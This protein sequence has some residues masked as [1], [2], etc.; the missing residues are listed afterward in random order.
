[1]TANSAP[2]PYV[3]KADSE[4]ISNSNGEIYYAYKAF[5]GNSGK[6]WYSAASS[7]RWVMFD[8][9]API[10][11]K[12]VRI[13]PPG[14]YFDVGFFPQEVTIMGSDDGENWIAIATDGGAEYVPAVNSPRI[15]MF[16]GAVTYR[17]FKFSFGLA[18]NGYAQSVVG[19][20]QFAV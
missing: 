2:A 8:A 9:G 1:M 6:S 11:V 10:E 3:A 20:I 15:I 4:Y 12:G 5:D 16:N 19:E 14:I 7:N 13:F 17:Y 18:Y